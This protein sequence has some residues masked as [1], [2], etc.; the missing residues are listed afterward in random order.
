MPKVLVTTNG[1]TVSLDAI[2]PLSKQLG[3]IVSRHLSVPE[4]WKLTPHEVTIT[5]EEL[6]PD[7]GD[8][9]GEEPF[10]QMSYDIQIGIEGAYNNARDAASVDITSAIQTDIRPLIPSNCTFD[11]WLKLLP[12]AYVGVAH[13]TGPAIPYHDEHPASPE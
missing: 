8:M 2:V 3:T 9:A 4:S 1:N 12:G 6:F 7:D 11:V 5:Y 10:E 13:G